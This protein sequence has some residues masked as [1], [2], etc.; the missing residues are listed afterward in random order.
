MQEGWRENCLPT[1]SIKFRYFGTSLIKIRRLEFQTSQ[2]TPSPM[3]LAS[4]RV[5]EGRANTVSRV[6]AWIIPIKIS[7]YMRF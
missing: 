3:M 6:M 5:L 1:F 7:S 4:P 2:S